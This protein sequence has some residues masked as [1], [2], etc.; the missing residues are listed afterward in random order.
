MIHKKYLEQA[1]R[2]RKDYLGIS[3]DLLE[4]TTKF[5]NNKS[6]IENTLQELIKIRKNSDTY[7][8]DTDYSSD[9]IEKLKEF[10]EQQHIIE[11]IYKPLND[12]MER[13]KDEESTLFNTIV[14][15]YPTI[16]QQDI[17]IEIQDYVKEKVNQ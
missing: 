9:I 2:I 7:V 15:E 8:S 16:Q 1:A 4:V 5:E 10:E 14:K 17:V 6:S 3:N 13:L 12:K 11:N